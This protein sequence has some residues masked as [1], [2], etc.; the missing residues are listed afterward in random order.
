[1]PM[2]DK[3]PNDAK[4]LLITVATAAIISIGIIITIFIKII[5]FFL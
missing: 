1:M 5:L 4:V 2:Q 3:M